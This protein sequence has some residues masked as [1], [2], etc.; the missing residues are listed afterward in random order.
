M[1]KI[2][3]DII[4]NPDRASWLQAMRE[5][6]MPIHSELT[7]TFKNKENA[8]MFQ[9]S[10]NEMFN[11]KLYEINEALSNLYLNSRRV[12]LFCD[13]DSKSEREL[14]RAIR[15]IEDQISKSVDLF[16]GPSGAYRVY[17]FLENAL[18]LLIEA[19]QVINRVNQKRLAYGEIRIINA[20]MARMIYLRNQML[21]WPSDPV[22]KSVAIPNG[23]KI[24]PGPEKKEPLHP[25]PVVKKQRIYDIKTTAKKPL[26]KLG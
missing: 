7:V 18:D 14:D 11:E 6:R 21:S 25:Q 1:R 19:Y 24:N 9:T 17:N 2:K 10:L 20:E 22:I 12:W 13:N 8:Q 26:K 16:Y 4:Q 23:I 15:Q 5:Y 3:V